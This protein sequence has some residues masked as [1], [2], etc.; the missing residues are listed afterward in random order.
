MSYAVA[1]IVLLGIA[2]CYA[3]TDAVHVAAPSVIESTDVP[4]KVALTD[5]SLRS[6]VGKQ[7]TVSG[8]WSPLGK[9]SGYVYGT[10]K[11]S[12]A[13]VYVKATNAQGLPRQT[14]FEN[15]ITDG[16]PVEV[17]GVLRWHESA[18]PPTSEAVAVQNAP[19]HFYFDAADT[20]IKV[21]DR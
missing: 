12:G 16:T 2:G 17:T 19:D 21:S 8:F 18:L 10:D 3:N 1:A 13:T 11:S 9:E 7:I 5:A 4:P 20:S 14:E 15:A 6:H